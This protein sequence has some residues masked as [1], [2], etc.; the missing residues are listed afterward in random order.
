[1][2]AGDRKTPVDWEYENV[3]FLSASAQEERGFTL[4]ATL[5]WNHY[6]R[7][8]VGY[9]EAIR[10]GAEQIVDTD[11]DNIPKEN[12]SFPESQAEFETSGQRRFY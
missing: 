11:D 5:P 10:L 8:M 1:M 9:L 3:Q 2:V 4:S 6:C 7:K 12:G